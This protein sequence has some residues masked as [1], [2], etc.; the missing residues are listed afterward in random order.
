[1]SV[2]ELQLWPSSEVEKT[3]SWTH[4]GGATREVKIYNHN[5]LV[6]MYVLSFWYQKAVLLMWTVIP[7]ASGKLERDTGRWLSQNV[8]IHSYQNL[9]VFFLI[10]PSPPHYCKPL[11]KFFSLIS[12][13]FIIFACLS[14]ALVK[15]QSLGDLYLTLFSDITSGRCLLLTKMQQKIPSKGTM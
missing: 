10:K 4:P 5:N 9:A 2:R 11:I 14:I 12:W 8:I 3:S 7:K 6:T 13:L 1:M 15:G